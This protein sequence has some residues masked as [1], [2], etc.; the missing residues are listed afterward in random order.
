MGK[1]PS[2]ILKSGFLGVFCTL[3][4]LAAVGAF[5]GYQ[6]GVGAR[7]NVPP[8]VGG[9]VAGAF[10]FLVFFWPTAVAVGFLGGCL[11]GLAIEGI[12]SAA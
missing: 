5:L 6:D 1:E 7:P 3:L 12:E 10:S 9:A 11:G 8:G 2:G 4:A